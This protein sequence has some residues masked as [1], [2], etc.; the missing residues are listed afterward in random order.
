MPDYVDNSVSQKD[1]VLEQLFIVVIMPSPKN[2]AGA[3]PAASSPKKAKTLD[4]SNQLEALKNMTSVVADTG[5]KSGSR[6][7]TFC[8]S[9]STLLRAKPLVALHNWI[10]PHRLVVNASNKVYFDLGDFDKIK[11]FR[12]D[13]ATTN[14]TLLYQAAQMPEYAHVMTKAIKNAQAQ[15]LTGEAL[16]DEVRAFYLISSECIYARSVTSWP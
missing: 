6:S 10:F 13:D 3:H 15:N 2:L 8:K 14:P 7:Y 12:P 5:E 11:Q 9:Y 4:A 1:V 16:V